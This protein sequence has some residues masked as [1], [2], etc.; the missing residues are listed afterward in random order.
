MLPVLCFTKE[1]LM[2]FL[3]SDFIAYFQKITPFPKLVDDD[4]IIKKRQEKSLSE[5]FNPIYMTVSRL[6]DNK[7]WGLFDSR[8]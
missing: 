7:I 4:L 1:T 5:I 8:N 3:T 2:R 6:R